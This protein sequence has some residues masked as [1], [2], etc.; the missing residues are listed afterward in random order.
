MVDDDN[1]I[2]GVKCIAMGLERQTLLLVYNETNGML[3]KSRINGAAKYA[4]IAND[5]LDR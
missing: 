3:V 5:K 1:S 2:R 4:T